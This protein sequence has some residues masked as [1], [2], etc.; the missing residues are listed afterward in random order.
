MILQSGPAPAAVPVLPALTTIV[1]QDVLAWPGV[2]R[3]KQS[4]K[5]SPCDT[6]L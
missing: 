6:G 3:V 2:V 1:M 4:V 5:E